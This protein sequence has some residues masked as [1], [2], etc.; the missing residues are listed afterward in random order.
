[1]IIKGRVDP[2]QASRTAYPLEGFSVATDHFV[3]RETT[4]ENPFKPHRHKEPELWY[5]IEGEGVVSLNGQ[6]HPVTTGD[7][8]RL[9]PWVEHGLSTGGSLRWICMG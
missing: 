5:V 8:I 7:L 9:D 4:P 3:V 2:S 6:D 1:M